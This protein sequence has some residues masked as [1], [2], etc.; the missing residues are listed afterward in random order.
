MRLTVEFTTPKEEKFVH[1]IGKLFHSDL[2]GWTKFSDAVVFDG[3]QNVLDKIK[4]KIKQNRSRYKGVAYLE[5]EKISLEEFL[6]D[7]IEATSLDLVENDEELD[8]QVIRHMTQ[9]EKLKAKLKRRLPAHKKWLRKYKRITSKP[10]Y[11]PNIMV[12]RK[13]KRIAKLK[14]KR[15]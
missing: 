3:N 6:N 4:N 1:S 15:S 14:R 9:S 13:L 12:S 7:L 10:G 11:R 5:S 8:E 2:I